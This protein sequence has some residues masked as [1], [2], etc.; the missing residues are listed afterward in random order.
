[1]AS[2]RAGFSSH[3]SPCPEGEGGGGGGGGEKMR[4]TLWAELYIRS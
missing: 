3:L 4:V 1:M 2:E